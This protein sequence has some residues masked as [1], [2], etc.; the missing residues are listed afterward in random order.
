M[1]RLEW[2]NQCQKWKEK[3]PVYQEIF[4]DDTDGINIYSV[5]ESLNNICKSNTIFISDA[6]TAAYA[7]G[8]NLKLKKGQKI[9]IPASQGEMGFALPASIGAALTAK[10]HNI[11][12]ITGDGSLNTNIQELATIKANKLPV[13]IIVLNNEGYLSIRNTQKNYYK[14]NIYGESKNTGLWFPKLSEISK[15]YE[16]GYYQAKTILELN[17][18]LELYLENNSPILFDVKCKVWQEVI[19]TLALKF[20]KEKNKMIQT[21][22]DDMYPFLSDEELI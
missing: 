6:G 21:G 17:K 16:L 19:P 5:I 18:S 9:I 8:Q 15:A 14:N 3:W 2:I 22:L 12:V 11:V 13:K 4:Q 7:V 20:D 1:S 10:E